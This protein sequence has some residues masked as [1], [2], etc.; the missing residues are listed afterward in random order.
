[1]NRHCLNLVL[2][3][4]T[5]DRMQFS[6]VQCVL[7]GLVGYSVKILNLHFISLKIKDNDTALDIF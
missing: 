7:K 3:W 6:V 1:M 5:G 4:S 2:S